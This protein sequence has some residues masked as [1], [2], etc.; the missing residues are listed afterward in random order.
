[1]GCQCEG[2]MQDGLG[3][4]HARTRIKAHGRRAGDVPCARAEREGSDDN[5]THSI[6]V[7]LLN[8]TVRYRY[9][10]VSSF[11]ARLPVFRTGRRTPPVP[12]TGI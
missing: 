10:E 2:K 11:Q 4:R 5:E 6:S 12:A 3:R 1:M 7:L 8:S 9:V